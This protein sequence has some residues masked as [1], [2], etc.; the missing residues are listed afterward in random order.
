MKVFI[1]D[2]RPMGKAPYLDNYS[3]LCKMYNIEYRLCYWDKT[4]DG[5]TSFEHNKIVIRKKWTTGIFKIFDFFA[6]AKEIRKVVLQEHFTHLVIVNSIWALLLYRL[7]K[8]FKN[9]YILDI[10]DYKCENVYFVKRFL[11]SIIENSFMTTISSNGFKTFLPESNKIIV[12]H[13]ISNIEFVEKE[14]TLKNDSSIV[15]IVYLGHVR[16][17]NE[18][19]AL[20]KRLRNNK[21]YTLTYIGTY[22]K[23]FILKDDKRLSA[24]NIKF[25]G[26]FDNEK[27]PELY[28]KYD[29]ISSVYGCS[30]TSVVTLI[31]NR[32]YDCLQY[33][34]PIIVSKG[35]FLSD[36][37]TE[38]SLGFSVDIYRDNIINELDCYISMFDKDD[39]ICG[40]NKYLSRI[41]QE[42]AEY[43]NKIKQFLENE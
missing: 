38:Y 26:R 18:N 20:I 27:K 2:S 23:G 7:L 13:N 11:K 22:A 32:L 41:K 12:T 4:C 21:K 37:V 6:I 8:K 29:M 28:K 33:K 30:E 19:T 10:R 40:C 31:P 17:F 24:D 3:N 43:I 42:Q 14:P 39:F 36:I 35:T 1:F 16:Y 9:R 5:N 15:N 34:K 25:F